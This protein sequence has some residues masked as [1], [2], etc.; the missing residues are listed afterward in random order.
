LEQEVA[1]DRPGSLSTGV[2]LA[3]TATL[4]VLYKSGTTIRVEPQRVPTDYV[5][6][7]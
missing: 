4:P 7:S 5:R 2:T 3:I 6:S 1:G